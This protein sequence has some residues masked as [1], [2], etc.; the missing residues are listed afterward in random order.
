MF[1][2]EGIDATHNPEFTSCEFYKAF[3]G[4]D[5]LLDFSE[6][7]VREMALAANGTTVITVFAE[8]EEGEVT[9]EQVDLAEPFA[10]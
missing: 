4:I 3:A 2:N 1:R 9:G 8:D 10:R 7:I 5:Y 6:S